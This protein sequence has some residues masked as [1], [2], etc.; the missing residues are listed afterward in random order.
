MLQRKFTRM[1]F[2][3][4]NLHKPEYAERLN[5]LNMMSLKTRRLISD[6]MSL[7]KIFH[8]RIDTKLNQ[9]IVFFNHGRSTRRN[10]ASDRP[11]FY[12]ATYSSNAEQNEPLNRMQDHHNKY[13]TGC[14][15]LN[16]SFESF[17]NSVV[18]TAMNSVLIND[19][20]N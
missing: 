13:F 19:N 15:I 20:V 18:N 10:V 5:R 4:F 17:K 9:S 14:D 2:F 12:T 3:K 1:F 11:I 6:E 8:R 7:Y 16:T